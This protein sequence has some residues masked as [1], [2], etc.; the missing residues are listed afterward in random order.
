[1]DEIDVSILKLL[2]KN[3]RVSAKAIAEELFVSP[4]TV[5]ARIENMKKS[6]IIKGFYTE[7]NQE[8]FGNS[9]HAFIE[10]EVAPTMRKELYELLESY[11]EVR[12]CCRI[13]G[14]YSLL[15]EVVFRNTDEMDHFT[16]KLQHYGRTKTQ[17]VFSTV[18][19]HN[20][21]PVDISQ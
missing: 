12:R 18:I 8:A 19:E 10:M 17:I 13:T 21:I 11:K 6:G 2:Q 15:M 16:M 20:V 1:M 4:P 14:E 9:I 3:A 5:S 7:I